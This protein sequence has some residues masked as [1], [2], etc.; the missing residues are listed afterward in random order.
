M[1]MTI[2]LIEGAAAG[3][4]YIAA[5]RSRP[6]GRAAQGR[7][8][9]LGQDL[10]PEEAVAQV[11]ADVRRRG[12]VALREWTRRLDGVALVTLYA[13]SEEIEA[14]YE[15]VPA[16]LQAALR[17]A[18][19]RIRDY[20]NH[21]PKGSWLHWD[22]AGGALG[23]I[24]RP[25]QRA[26][27]YVPGGSAAYP[28]S[29]LMTVI[30]AQVAGVE[31]IVV[32]TPPGPTGRGAA[33]TL[34]AAHV[35]GLES[36]WLLGGAQAVAALAYGTESMPRVDK[37][38]GAGGRFVTLAKRQVYGDV[39]I[40]GL[41]GPTETLLIADETADPR[42]AAADL[43][44]QAEHDP[45][46]TALLLTTD[47]NLAAAVQAEVRRQLAGLER[48][49]VIA[50]ALEGQGAVIVVA[51]LDE[52]LEL[53]NLYAPEHLCLLVRDPWPLVGRVRN[54]GGIFC[55]ELAA[56]ALGDY[57]LGPSHVMPTGGT[58]RFGSPLH[59]GDFLKV[60]SLFAPAGAMVAD[61]AP[62]AVVIAR[63]EGLTAHGA[64]A[65]ARGEAD[66]K[67]EGER[68][69][70]TGALRKSGAFQ[71]SL[72]PPSP[73][74]LRF[75]ERGGGAARRLSEAKARA[76]GVGRGFPPLRHDLDA[77]HPYAPADRES[78]GGWSGPWIRLHAN[79]SPYSPSPHVRKALA[80]CAAYG[81]YPEYPAVRAAVAGYAGID[82]AQVVLGNG[83]NELID[84]L[85]R[86]VL[87]PGEGVLICPPTF[88]MY[89]FFACLGHHPVCA[90]PRQD[91]FTLE[92]AAIEA[93][94]RGEK[95]PRMLFVTSPA[96]PDGQAIPPAI[97]EQL[98]Q[99]PLVVV[100]DEAYIEFGGESARPL[101]STCENLVI[102]RSFSKWAGLAGLRVGYALLSASLAGQLERICIPYT[103]NAAAVTAVLATLEDLPAAQ[104]NVARVVAERERLRTALARLPG[105]EVLPSQG[106]FLL[107]RTAGRSGAELAGALAD[108]G[109]LV[110]AFSEPELGP[111]VR[112]TVG[113]PEENE[114]LLQALEAIW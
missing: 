57:V 52:A 27:V 94:V 11:V 50:A 78:L 77:F 54:A 92:V 26:G 23:Q 5:L 59:V 105:M 87:E 75:A 81:R 8:E 93:Q 85:M 45:L 69:A 33:T 3:R 63:A 24:V 72:L 31:E 20:H 46:A 96:N 114:A 32:T 88:E 97:V 113:R 36:V 49:D 34:A 90:V 39:G 14:A 106:N 38:V 104:A 21:E 98:L 22:D 110:R 82:A 62:D 16:E 79:E 108:R 6:A 80:D 102:L 12:D 18:A 101:L 109:I 29:L 89:R 35:V 70:C 43:L 99:L 76:A 65:A 44:A 25:V 7:P 86:L 84:L 73:S 9:R 55:G 48:V 30:P 2:R 42:L 19:G 67:G 71:S 47:R 15:A 51:D 17:R 1:N 100:V 10:S 64:A 60:T 40:D 103:V 111:Y 41:H 53:A 56:E 61:L 112:I 28:S 95:A 4:D 83:S 66:Q 74:P 37:I 58:A 13:G 68:S 91:D 107:C